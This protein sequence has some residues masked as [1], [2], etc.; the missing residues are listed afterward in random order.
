[1]KETPLL[2]A[3][4]NL[5]QW[6]DKISRCWENYSSSPFIYIIIAP[7][8]LSLAVSLNHDHHQHCSTSQTHVLWRWFWL[9]IITFTS[10]INI[11]HYLHRPLNIII[12]LHYLH[13]P[14]AEFFVFLRR[15][16]PIPTI[17]LVEASYRA[18]VKV[19]SIFGFGR[20]KSL[21]F[22]SRKQAPLA[23]LGA[24]KRIL[25]AQIQKRILPPTFPKN[26]AMS[27]S[28]LAWAV[29]NG[30]VGP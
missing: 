15:V 6:L 3:K 28:L 13:R 27:I 1:M 30:I 24:K 16:L 5:E 17:G 2:W 11:P 22:S 20:R 29:I 14:C 7:V 18:F 25:D 8:L 12:I 26:V 9:M 19:V 10:I 4:F 23:I 21:L